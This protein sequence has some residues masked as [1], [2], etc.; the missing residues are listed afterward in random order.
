MDY[1][2]Q[3][4]RMNLSEFTK[5]KSI[6]WRLFQDYYDYMALS[7]C[8]A[9]NAAQLQSL[10][11]DLGDWDEAVIIWMVDQEAY[12][13]SKAEIPNFF[14][15]HVL[16]LESNQE[17][18][19][20]PA[21][22]KV[23]LSSVCF[24]H[25]GLEMF[26]ALN[27]MS[28]HTLSLWNCP[29]VCVLVDAMCSLKDPPRLKSLELVEDWRQPDEGICNSLTALLK[30][31]TGLE[32]L[33]LLVNSAEDPML[34]SWYNLVQGIK[35]HKHT[36]KRLVLH[37]RFL[38]DDELSDQCG[39]ICDLD[40]SKFE[41]DT[42]DLMRESNIECFGISSTPCS[43][44][45]LQPLWFHLLLTITSRLGKSTKDNETII[46]D[47]SCEKLNPQPHEHDRG[48]RLHVS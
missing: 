34:R 3:D 38:N 7:G 15:M 17:T 26:H 1:P 13:H 20:F 22:V 47:H 31:F 14:A 9:A 12:G 44:V 43:L 27:I 41:S 25:F 42:I 19:T 32:D 10:T 5:L 33:Y 4:L 45:R 18:V 16:C 23:S 11:I 36:L 39:G 6:S 35:R 29:G 28:L 48:I 40:L 2:D 30:K 37:E 21:L 24:A 46:Q 8:L